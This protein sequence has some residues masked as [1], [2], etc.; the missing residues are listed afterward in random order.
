MQRARAAILA[1]GGADAVNSFTRFYLALL[2]QIPY[3]ACPNVPPEFL[4][5]PTWFPVNLYSI[6]SWS[7]TI[8]V[9]LSIMSAFR[10]VRKIEPERGIREL[11]LTDPLDW[12][13]PRCP[14]LKKSRRLVSWENFFHT[15]DKLIQIP[16]A[17]R[18]YAA[19]PDG[20]LPR[21]DAGCSSDSTA[22][23]AWGRFSRR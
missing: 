6:S 21:P 5:A 1:G 20:P 11:F 23:T 16:A 7:R 12:P 15:V 14:G 8:L 22:A 4:L 9:P 18:I 13:Y 3:D 2:G 17:H 10:P 19:P